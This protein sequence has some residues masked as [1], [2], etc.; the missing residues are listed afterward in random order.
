[1]NRRTLTLVFFLTFLFVFFLLTPS[2]IAGEQ[3]QCSCINE[4]RFLYLAQPNITGSDVAE[5]QQ[6]LK[7]LGFYIGKVDG[8]YGPKTHE[9]VKNFQEKARLNPSGK[10]D[11]ATWNA[12]ARGAEAP[13]VS[14]NPGDKPPGKVSILIDTN[15]KT[16]TVLSDGKTF[17]TFPCAVGKSSTPTPVGE[18]KIIHKGGNWGGGFGTRWMGLNVPWGIYGIHGTNKPYSIG[19]A[20][21]HGCI[22]M[23]NQHVETIYPWVSIGTPVKIVG[24]PIMPPDKGFRKVMERGAVGPDVVQVQLR[25]KEKGFL[26]GSADG[27]FGA[28]TELAVNFF[29][30]KNGLECTGIVDEKIY[31]AL[32]IDV[33]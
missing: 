33:K 1:M 14:G 15:K 30:A 6:R 27:R 25:L 5:L 16:L 32:G 18:W 23:F 26:M 20:A 2:L 8:I 3:P 21:S 11:A 10:V 19:T 9:A 29:Q 7:V 12:L 31:K 22:R 28:L 4:S 13:P 24:E 17:K